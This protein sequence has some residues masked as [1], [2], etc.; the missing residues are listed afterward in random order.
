VPIHWG[1]YRRLWLTRDEEAPARRFAELAA[2]QVPDVDVRV[3]P[4]GG[5]VEVPAEA[6]VG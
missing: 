6:V 4:V 3:L 1:T 2:E 5:T